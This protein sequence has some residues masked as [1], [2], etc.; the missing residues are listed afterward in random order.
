[1]V[2]MSHGG[3]WDPINRKVKWFFTDNVA[4]SLTYTATPPIDESGAH[5]FAGIFVIDDNPPVA[6]IGQATIVP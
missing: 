4:R 6:F 3:T 2:A 1:M 5:V